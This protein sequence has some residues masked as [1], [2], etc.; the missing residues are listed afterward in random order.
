MQQAT[1]NLLADMNAQPATLQ[2]GLI[3]ASASTDLVAPT[4]IITSPTAGATLSQGAAVVI[5]GTAADT[6]GG[7]VG[8]VEVSVDGGTTWHPANGRANWTYNWTPSASGSITIKSRAADDSGNLETP[9]AGVTVSVGTGAK[10]ARAASGPLPRPPPMRP[11]RT[12]ARSISGSSSP[13]SR[14]VPLPASGST[15]APTNTGTHIGNLWSSSGTLLA[16]ATFANETASGWQQVN[17]ASPVAITANTV[18]VA[19]YHAPVGRYANDN[20]YFATAGVDNPPLHALRDGVTAAAMASMPTA[21]RPRS[22]PPRSRRPITGWT[23]CSPTRS[24][25]RRRPRLPRTRRPMAQPALPR[26]PRRPRPSAR[27]SIRPRSTTTTFELRDPGNALV[28]ATV[29]YNSSTLTA[30]LTPGSPLAPA[31][32]LHRDRPWRCD[33]SAREGRRQAMRWP[34]TVHGRLRQPQRWTPRPPP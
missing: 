19:S 12:P 34:R 24:P 31:T 28:T 33:R 8:G 1:V 9:G 13:P 22:P 2:G 11:T 16:S 27:R 26:G 32:T 18:Y 10:R 23:W 20:A 14:M 5:S 15:R 21:A 25:T 3:P 30:T 17:F 6:G 4:S 7:V 29:A